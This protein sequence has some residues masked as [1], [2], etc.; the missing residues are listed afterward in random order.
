MAP[1]AVRVR[2]AAPDDLV[3]TMNVLDGAVLAVD[4]DAVR[5]RLAA[6][7]VLVAVAGDRVLG[8]LV[9]DPAGPPW[10]PEVGTGASRAGA[11]DDAT[12]AD[13]AHVVAVAVRRRRRDQGI[14]TALVEAAA[15]RA[16][17]LTAAFDADVRP[18]YESLGFAVTGETADGRRRGVLNCG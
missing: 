13:A 18:F 14:G 7:D 4:A 8:V 3:A 10:E 15:A 11:H 5:E 16:G 12:P 6:G 2:E 9:L 17:R 1:E